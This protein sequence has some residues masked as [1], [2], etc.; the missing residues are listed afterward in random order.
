M[1]KILPIL[2]LLALC[3]CRSANSRP[4]RVAER[5]LKAFYASDLEKAAALADENTRISLENTLN[6]WRAEGLTPARIQAEA[7]PVIIRVEGIIADD[8]RQAVC[9]YKVLT[10]PDDANALI[11][12]LLLVKTDEGWKASF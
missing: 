2:L 9:A 6:Q 12:T 3:G 10:S 8:G 1:R 11:E 7:Q 5:F 4:E